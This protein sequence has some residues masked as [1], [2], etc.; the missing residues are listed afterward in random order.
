MKVHLKLARWESTLS[1]TIVGGTNYS[2]LWSGVLRIHPGFSSNDRISVTKISDRVS[3]LIS[4]RGCQKSYFMTR[5]KIKFG[6]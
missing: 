6:G 5:K 2:H 1:S 3:A 4:S